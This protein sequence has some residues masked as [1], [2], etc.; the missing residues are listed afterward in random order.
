MTFETRMTRLPL[1][2]D[3]ERG[4]AAVAAH[5]PEATGTLRDALVGMA[6]SSP[7]LEGLLAKEAAWFAAALEDPEAAFADRKSVV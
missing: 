2:F 3:P 1:P 5:C 4:A 7:Y 6:G